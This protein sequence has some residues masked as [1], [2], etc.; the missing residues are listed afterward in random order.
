MR[1]R[2]L[3]CSGS[4]AEN[5]KTTSF[6]IDDDLLVDAGTG[7]HDLTLEEMVCIDHILLSH[8][9]LDHILAIPLL[10][11]TVLRRRFASKPGQPITVYA[12]EATIQALQS[13][14]FN[15]IIWPDFTRIPSAQ[16]PL[17]QFKSLE[18]GQ[19][20]ELNG[21]TIV[22]LPAKHT[23]PALGY[24][25]SSGATWW[26]FSGDTGP[27]PEFWGLMRSKKIGALFIETAFSDEECELAQLSGHH[28]PKTLAKELN[29]LKEVTDVYITHAKPGDV[30]KIEQQIQNISTLH[31]VQSLKAG[32][33]LHIE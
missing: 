31:R 8:S 23:V 10:A 2:V 5:C 29:L 22:N 1:V 28:C 32:T 11:D 24:A 27:N 30:L 9:H 3:G 21:R 6:L 12:L 15:G 13:H 18:E 33:V 14:I 16:N 7:V 19:T 26:V 25:I 17:I 4:V 20:W